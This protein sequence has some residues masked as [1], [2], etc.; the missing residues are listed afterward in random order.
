VGAMF[1]LPGVV[2]LGI[3]LEPRW[4]AARIILEAQGLSLAL[5]LIATARAWSDF[6][7]SNLSTWLFVGRLSFLLVAIAVLYISIEIH[8]RNAVKGHSLSVGGNTNC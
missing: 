8:R 2:G 5:I 1:A 7:Q 4:S 3:A 6:D